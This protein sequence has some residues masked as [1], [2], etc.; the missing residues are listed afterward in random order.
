MKWRKLGHIFDPSKH[1]LPNNCAEY[2]QSP[3]AL[4]LQDR[5]RIYFSTRESEANG[6]F[7][8]HIAFVDFNKKMDCCL[9]VSDRPVISLGSLGC[10]DEHGIF[11]MN[12]VQHG[13]DI[14]GFTCG[15]SRRVSVSVETSIGIAVSR[16]GGR[17]FERRADGP[18]MTSS[19]R[20]PMLVGDPFVVMLG[21][22]WHMWYI[23]GVKWAPANNVD[24]APARVYKI[25]H[26]T[27]VDTI[28]WARDGKQIISDVFGPDEC[29]ALPTVLKIGRRFH[30]YFCFRQATDFRKNPHRGYRLGYAFS[31]DLVTWTRDDQSA[32]ISFSPNGWDSAMLCYPHLFESE[33]SVY[34]LYN[35][36]E[37]G[38][39]GFG[40]ARFEG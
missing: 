34:L 24:P 22:V 18:V 36:N 28:N 1:S 38:R 17:T 37:F 21:G 23:F 5:V 29:Q 31:D 39:R 33:G 13:E 26:A 4:V 19:L 2:A 7:L 35:G 32:G 8:S 3:Q 11:P 20:E 27:S 25:A 10:F 40:L 30:M 12:V 6:K 16:D 9:G 14:Y 15:W